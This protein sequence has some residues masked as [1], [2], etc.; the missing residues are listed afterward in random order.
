MAKALRAGVVLVIVT[1]AVTSWAWAVERELAGVRLGQK[2]LDLLAQPGFGQPDYIGPLAT[3]GE[4]ESAQGTGGA[5]QTTAR[6]GQGGPAGPARAARRASRG[7]RMGQAPGGDL[8]VAERPHLSVSLTAAAARRGARGM[9][10]GRRGM[11]AGAA[12]GGARRAAARGTGARAARGATG[13]RTRAVGRATAEGPG[14]YWYYR[15]MADVVLVLTLDRVGMVTAITLTGTFPYRA[16]RTSRGIGLSNTYM[17]IIAQY[18]YPDRTAILGSALQ[19][20]YIDHGVRFQLEGMKVREIAIGAYVTAGVEAAP[21][22]TPQSTTPPAGLSD[23][24]L[25]GYL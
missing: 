25:R 18:G 20:T 7:M 24:E 16:G 8:G 1:T 22:Q 23:E 19:L 5:A 10:S 14:M 17:D 9:G 13:A 21:A 15:R 2:A 11:G 3:L 12:G 6:R 4:M